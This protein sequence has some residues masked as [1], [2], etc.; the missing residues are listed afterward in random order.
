MADEAA[1]EL[2]HPLSASFFLSR[3]E[4]NEQRHMYI[5]LY[6]RGGHVVLGA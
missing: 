3:E 1:Q 4:K 6:S 2:T 5:F